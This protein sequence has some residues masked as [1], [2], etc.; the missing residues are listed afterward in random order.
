MNLAFDSNKGG[1]DLWIEW[2][3]G[4][5][6]ECYRVLRPGG[7]AL[8]W[9]LPRTSHWIAIDWENAGFEVRDRVSHLFGS[10]MPKSHNV[11]KAIDKL[12]G[13]KREVIGTFKIG[14]Q[15]LGKTKGL[16]LINPSQEFKT[17]WD[18]TLPV[19][20][21][22]K[23]WDGWG[24][25]LKPAMED[26]WLLRKPL[27][28]KSI[29]ANVLKWGTGA[30]NIDACRVPSEQAYIDN[31][32]RLPSNKAETTFGQA[33]G[34]DDDWHK[35]PGNA[36]G[37]WPA[38]LVHDGSD[39][40]LA[41]FAK[42]GES[43]STSQPRRNSA[44]TNIAKGREYAHVTGGHDDA[45]TPARFFYC[46]KP[47]KAE[48]NADGPNTHPTVKS[49]ALM[50]YLITLITPPGGIVL[51]PFAGSGT[52]CKSA[53]ELG[54]DFVGI[55][56]EPEYFAVLEKRVGDD[57]SQLEPLLTQMPLILSTH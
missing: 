11:S 18:I 7:H 37:R 48:K 38:Q 57:T 35:F 10:G 20:D 4:I 30:I 36:N 43:K 40:V 34:Q 8:I 39:S 1:R 26:W 6:E 15:A 23:E 25:A 56:L 53:K 45:G 21:E 47:S 12:A 51:D 33:K 9:A 46:A 3:Q 54:F 42:Y 5:A 41:E 50:R 24:S 22:A 44:R 16:G 14:G 19:T 13:A 55:E 28:E 2:M 52:T 32:I 31:G 49:M 29:A 27:S 17:E